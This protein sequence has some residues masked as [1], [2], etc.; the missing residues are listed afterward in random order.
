[1]SGSSGTSFIVFLFGTLFFIIFNNSNL[2]N[3]KINAE[4]R[5]KSSVMYSAIYALGVILFNLYINLGITADTCGT[6]QWGTAVYATLFPWILIFGI[7]MIFL[8]LFPGWLTPFSNT[9]GYLIAYFAGV[10]G[11]IDK[12][13][14]P[15]T[16]GK[17]TEVNEEVQVAL[18]HIYGNKS[19]LINEI[20]TDSF[21]DFWS[22]MS[23]LMLPGAVNNEDLKNELFSMIVLKE[24]AAKWLWYM[25]S[26]VLAMSVSLNYIVSSA[27][28]LSTDEMKA[29]HD[30]YE[31]TIAKEK[32][33]SENNKQRIYSTTE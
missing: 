16:K 27:C 33:E 6:T 29:R 21:D 10:G 7:L 3:R 13:F 25:L 1:M 8:E 28:S 24:S 19:L 9:F 20:T 31:E 30:E 4:A 11:V 23:S 5:F 12:I 15:L 17:N 26:G 2:S 18:S 32:E 22:G 14:K